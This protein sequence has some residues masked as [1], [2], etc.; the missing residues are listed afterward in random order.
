MRTGFCTTTTASSMSARAES[1]G[2]TSPGSTRSTTGCLASACAPWSSCPSC[3]PRWPVTA[4]QD[5]LQLPGHHFAAARLGRMAAPRDR[6]RGASGRAG[7]ALTRFAQ[8]AFEVWNEPDLEVFWSGTRLEYLRLYDESAGRSSRCTRGCGS[9]GR[10]RPRPTGSRRS[11]RTPR[12]TG[13]PLDFV[14][15]HTYGNVPLD[16]RPALRRHGFDGLPIW[17]TEWGVGATHFG[18]VHDWRHRRAVHPQ[19]AASARR[20]GWT[21]SPT[22]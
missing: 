17:W 19:R 1:C 11:R 22:G 20:G 13:V 3:R 5:G 6:A 16:P 14:S 4:E 18:D 8:W 15:T 7:T 21:R 2:S 10:R 12:E 9:A